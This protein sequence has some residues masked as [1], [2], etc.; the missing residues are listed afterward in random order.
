MIR[1]GVKAPEGTMIQI[2]KY[3]TI[4]AILLMPV[5]TPSDHKGRPAIIWGVIMNLNIYI[6]MC[7]Y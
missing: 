2:N 4:P 7:V 3:N 6:D 5:E 1:R